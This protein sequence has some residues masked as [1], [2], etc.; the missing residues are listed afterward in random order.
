MEVIIRFLGGSLGILAPASQQSEP[1][2]SLPTP[3][4]FSLLS[5]S[6]QCIVKAPDR[7]S[8]SSQPPSLAPAPRSPSPRHPVPLPQSPT[9]TL[10]TPIFSLPQKISDDV[11]PEEGMGIASHRWNQPGVHR[12]PRGTFSSRRCGP[13]ASAGFRPDPASAAPRGG[14]GGRADAA[15][16]RCAGLGSRF[17][18]R[19][20][21]RVGGPRGRVCPGCREAFEAREAGVLR[22]GRALLGN[23]FILEPRGDSG[24][25]GKALAKT[26]S[27]P[28]RNQE[29]TPNKPKQ[30]E[31]KHL[32]PRA[33]RGVRAFAFIRLNRFQRNQTDFKH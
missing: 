13:A 29:K 31:P 30:T 28:K 8:E 23:S 2:F 6:P 4:V 18:A 26:P 33:P 10:K 25:I 19:G 5:L 27:S 16:P 17:R 14:S 12:A 9:H 1:K 32:T 15:R 7:G 20:S 24:V 11:S 21:G 3:V 22:G